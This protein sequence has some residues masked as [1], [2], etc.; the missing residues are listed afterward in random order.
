MAS[1]LTIERAASAART[2]G[3]VPARK[4]VPPARVFTVAAAGAGLAFVDATIVNVAFPDLQADFS[5]TSLGALSWVLNA[6]N[7]V[8]AA[9]LVAAGRFADLLGRRRMFHIGIVVFTVA[10]VACAAAPSVGLLIGAR[11]LQAIGAAI[12]A[13]AALAAGLGPSLGGVLVEAGGWRLAF[14]VNLPLGIAALLAGRRVLVESRAPGRR[15]TPDL[16]GAGLAGIAIAVAT[17]GIV[18]GEDW[19]GRAPLSSARSA[20]RSR[21]S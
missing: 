7:I 17:L 4:R 18:Q 1:A 19:A 16:A 9:L 15:S 20:R 12:M 2:A 6:Y 5:G 8:F 3:S 14:L 21:S 13:P 10:S 11:A